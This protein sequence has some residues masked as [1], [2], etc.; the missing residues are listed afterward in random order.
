VLP[1]TIE[2]AH[3]EPEEYIRQIYVEKMQVSEIVVG[4]SHA[5]GRFGKG[6]VKLLEH[7]GTRY[8]F[9]VHVIPPMCIGDTPVT[10]SQIRKLILDGQTK[11]AEALL[12]H[13]Y[14]LTGFVIHGAG[15]GRQLD[16]PTANIDFRMPHVLLPRRGVYAIRVKLGDVWRPG[17]MNLGIRPTFGTGRESVEIHILDFDGDIY[18]EELGLEII[19]RLRDEIRFPSV[20]DL[21]AQIIIDVEKTRELFS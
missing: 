13:P 6:N 8:G 3:T 4:Y 17:V 5:F 21:K 19:E 7:E 10:S 2:F 20:D 14:I 1:F 18:G 15:R 9:R 16:F 11:K 12:G